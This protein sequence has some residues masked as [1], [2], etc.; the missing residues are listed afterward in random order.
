M[1]FKGKVSLLVFSILVHQW[2]HLIN[3][4]QNSCSTH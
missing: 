3:W 1:L 2:Q 4:W